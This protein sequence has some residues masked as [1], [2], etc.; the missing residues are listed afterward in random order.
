MQVLRIK[1]LQNKRLKR[2]PKLLPE[3][4]DG[5]RVKVL[6]TGCSHCSAMRENTK[7]AVAELGEYQGRAQHLAVVPVPLRVIAL[8][9]KHSGSDCTQEEGCA[10]FMEAY[11]RAA[12]EPERSRRKRRK[13]TAD[14]AEEETRP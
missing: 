5:A 4:V 6:A 13:K 9:I 1:D 10:I 14:G 2:Q 7:A 11:L 8:M 3:A 12:K